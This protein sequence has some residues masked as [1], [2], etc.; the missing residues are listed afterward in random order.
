L[1]DIPAQDLPQNDDD[2]KAATLA[3]LATALSKATTPEAADTP[4]EPANPP[5]EPTNTPAEPTDPPARGRSR[6]LPSIPRTARL[7]LRR[8]TALALAVAL[9]L[10]LNAATPTPKLTPPAPTAVLAVTSPAATT[11][12]PSKSP[13]ASTTPGASRAPGPTLIPSPSPTPWL[14]TASPTH[15][16]PIAAIT[17]SDLMLDS[18]TSPTHAART[19]T[20]TSDGP[21]IVTASIVSTSPTDSTTLCIKVDAG[22]DLCQSGAT[23]ELSEAATWDHSY[24]T[25]TLVSANAATPTVDVAMTWPADH[26]SISMAH[27][28]FEGSPNPDSLRTLTATFKTRSAGP[29]SLSA[30]WPSATAD[31][32]LTLTDISGSEE[33]ALDSKSY[34]SA[35]SI[36]PGYARVAAAAH[37][38]RIVLYN[39]G[40]YRGLTDLAATIAFP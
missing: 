11:T 7:W 2:L 18:A 29:L 37:T 22:Y 38:Y 16:S 21:G 1:D 14:A 31:A 3:Q 39:E 8:T 40:A 35:G 23:P 36:A 4:A 10:G 34:T 26:P 12:Q 17:F 28:R 25:V 19:F 9:A 13:V 32:T 6:R 5:A 33:L 30:A 20:F 24:W 15:T 27:G